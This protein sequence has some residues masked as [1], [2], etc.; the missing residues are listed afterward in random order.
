MIRQA[1]TSVWP[2]IIIW[3]AQHCLAISFDPILE[4]TT[5]LV[6][7]LSTLCGWLLYFLHWGNY[8]WMVYL[9]W[10]SLDHSLDHEAWISHLWTQG[11]RILCLYIIFVLHN[12]FG[13][14]IS[15]QHCNGVNMLQLLHTKAGLNPPLDSCR[16]S[17]VF[18][19]SEMIFR[20]MRRRG[21]S[22]GSMTWGGGRILS[23]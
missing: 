19:H 8:W 6:Y 3:W 14:V 10:N 23:R 12:L 17:L 9:W 5:H 1:Q 18:K 13:F 22:D 16:N 7:G 21:Q 4:Y 15:H 11:L 2:M 20:L